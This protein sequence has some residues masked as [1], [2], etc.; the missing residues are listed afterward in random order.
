MSAETTH[1][2]ITVTVA[3]RPRRVA[4]RADRLFDGVRVWDGAAPVLLI[5][6]ETI[7]AV[8]E[9][10]LPADADVMDL[11]GA[12]VLPGLVD[13]HVHL[14]FDASADPVTGLAGRD[15]EG[16]RA[17]MTAAAR[18]ALAGGVTAIRD[19]GD[20]DYLSLELRARPGLP[21]IVAA[22]PPITT[23]LGHCHFLGGQT[24]DSPDGV[25]R[26]VREH[27]ERG[28]DVIKVMATWHHDSGHPPGGRPVRPRCPD[29]RSG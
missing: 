18:I 26:A 23:P 25:R 13:T 1:T 22:G 14:A 8:L 6:W 21:T 10:E 24:A 11:A 4:L 29:R 2:S 27:A 5:D 3:E 16:V 17:A 9:G 20:R 19:L 15:D 12:T 28:C 7:V